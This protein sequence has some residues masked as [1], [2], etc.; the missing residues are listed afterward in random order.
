MTCN[1]ST[2]GYKG[3]VGLFELMIMNNTLREMIM[4]NCSTDELREVARKNG[5]L[6]LRDAGMKVAFEG[7]TTPDEVVRETIIDG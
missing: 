4:Q 2:T 7:V 1:C 6:T 3:R 5:M